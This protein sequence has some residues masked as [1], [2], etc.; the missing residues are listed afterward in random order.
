MVVDKRCGLESY[1]HSLSLFFY[2]DLYSVDVVVL[3]MQSFFLEIIYVEYF[4]LT[5]RQSC[6]NV[7]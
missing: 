6:N 4:T 7:F 1:W 2:R 5:F 3:A